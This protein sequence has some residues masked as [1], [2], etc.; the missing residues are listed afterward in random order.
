MP[1]TLPTWGLPANV[2]PDFGAVGGRSTLTDIVGALLTI[3]LI[4]AVLML[5][6]CA[7]AWAI[8]SAT[9]NAQTAGRG[10]LGVFVA[11]A[12]AALAG[13]GVTWMNFLLRVGTTL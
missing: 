12:G 7:I 4:V 3:T 9:G 2:Y 1:A 5:V 6:I 13:A 10:R 8:G 11:L